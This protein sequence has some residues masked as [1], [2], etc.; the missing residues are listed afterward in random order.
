MYKEYIQEYVLDTLVTEAES[1]MWYIAVSWGRSPKL[2]AIYHILLS[3]EV[4]IWLIYYSIPSAIVLSL[5]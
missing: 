4:T 3:A 5:H 1:N 2:T